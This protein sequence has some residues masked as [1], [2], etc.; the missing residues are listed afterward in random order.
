MNFLMALEKIRIPFLDVLMQGITFF[1][2]E[3]VILSVVCTFYWCINKRFAY[4]LGLN[5]F[6]A[7]LLV[8]TLKITFRIPRPW[9]LEPDF[10]AVESALPGA[11]G[12][13]F[14]SGHTQGATSLYTNLALATKKRWAKVL[15]ICA[16]LLVGFSRMYL[17]VHTPKDVLVSLL[18]SLLVAGFIWRCRLVLLKYKNTK[19]VTIA[20][21]ALAFGVLFYAIFQISSAGLNSEI[22][23]D[24]FKAAGA[25]VGF[26]AGWYLERT[27]LKFTT[28]CP[29]LYQQGFKLGLGLL[30]TAVLKVF[31]G[32]LPEGNLG[33][34]FLAYGILVFWIIFLY[35]LFFKFYLNKRKH[36]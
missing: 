14:P 4:L 22:L 33:F 9:V 13:S 10:K 12:Y 6:V 1:G 23:R 3:L 32:L 5:Y 18:L 26:A 15:S 20:L 24:A 27:R 35:P 36:S 7:G 30:S 11:T 19:K 21:A 8:Q 25:G 16:F 28:K 34:T 29:H 17:G 2:E 31:L